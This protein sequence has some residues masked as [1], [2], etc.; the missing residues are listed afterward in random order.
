MSMSHWGIFE[1]FFS[2]KGT[3]TECVNKNCD[4]PLD[5]KPH[6]GLGW[7]RQSLS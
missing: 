6:E 3:G 7:D 5:A 4:M 1:K 2:V